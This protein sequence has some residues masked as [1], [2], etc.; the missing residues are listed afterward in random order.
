VTYTIPRRDE[1]ITTSLTL[2]LVLGGRVR[3]ASCLKLR[4][5]SVGLIRSRDEVAGGVAEICHHPGDIVVHVES[6]DHG[7]VCAREWRCR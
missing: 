5:D 7:D 3:D 4:N 6:E 2:S 1:D